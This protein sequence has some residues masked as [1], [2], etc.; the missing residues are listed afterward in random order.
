[1]GF[2]PEPLPL[3]V[4]GARLG[5]VGVKVPPAGAAEM[6]ALAALVAAEREPGALAAVFM[7]ALPAKSHDAGARLVAS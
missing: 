4:V 2:L 1:M 3:D 6:H 7:V 5:A